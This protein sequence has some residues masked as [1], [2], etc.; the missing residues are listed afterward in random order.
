M[1]FTV[2]EVLTRT[3]NRLNIGTTT[4]F[5]SKFLEWIN[6]CNAEIDTELAL[7]G[8]GWRSTT[9]NYNIVANQDNYTLTNPVFHIST[10]HY[11]ISEKYY[12]LLYDPGILDEG[13][14]PTTPEDRSVTK[15]ALRGNDIILRGIPAQ[16]VTNGLRVVGFPNTTDYT[17]SGATATID[18]I[19]LVRLLYVLYLCKTYR[20]QFSQDSENIYEKRW[21]SLLGRFKQVMLKR[22]KGP[23]LLQNR[24]R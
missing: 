23:T 18:E 8:L 5:D 6:D 24:M 15:W 12:P 9:V 17:D 4:K 1:S 21:Q 10:V 20:D 16:A 14:N 13:Y 22:Y 19:N 11:K 7:I 3:K 2:S